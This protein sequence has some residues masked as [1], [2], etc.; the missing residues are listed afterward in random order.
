MKASF[1]HIGVET[2]Y[3][4][5]WI[6]LPAFEFYWHYHPQVELTYIVSGSGERI[7][8]DSVESF[9]AGD[10]VLVGPDLPHTWTSSGKGHAEDSCQ[11]IVIQFR[12]EIFRAHPLILPEF[13]AI[14]HLLQQ[15]AR[16]IR[17]SSK[18]AEQTGQHLQELSYKQ[19]LPW[20]T[21]FWTVL[22]F[23]GSSADHTFLSSVG[24]SPSLNKLKQDRIARIFGYIIENLSGDIRLKQAAGLVCLT[25]TSFSRFF[26]RNTG[27]TFNGYV[28]EVRLAHACRLLTDYPE[29]SVSTVG[30]ESGFRSSTHFNRMFLA[31][32]GCPPSEFRRINH[33]KRLRSPEVP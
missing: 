9:S 24:Y 1:E 7:V 20:L 8:G 22:D 3:Q 13:D 31:S 11:A 16:G 6:S 19:G 27:M 32:K 18:V 21:G 25:E 28:N 33:P 10:L 26:R 4:Q 29:M 15:S 17:F 23:L 12:P 14:R 2:H 30:W 5:R